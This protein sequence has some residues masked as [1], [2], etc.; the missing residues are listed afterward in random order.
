MT[1]I[2]GNVLT[3]RLLILFLILFFAYSC[4]STNKDAT[5]NAQ[6]DKLPALEF[7]K[8]E[9][10]RQ[11]TEKRLEFRTAYP[12]LINFVNEK[13]AAN[14]NDSI[15][16][17]TDSVYN[18]FLSYIPAVE[19]LEQIPDDFINSYDMD[20]HIYFDKYGIASIRFSEY[21]YIA[22][23]A[24]GMTNFYSENYDLLKFK[25][26]TLDDIFANDEYLDSL[27]SIS[28]EILYERSSEQGMRPDSNWIQ[29]GTKP[30]KLYFRCFNLTEKGLLFTFGPY[31]VASYAEGPQEITIPYSWVE[32]ILDKNS[33]A[34]I[35]AEMNGE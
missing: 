25:K 33:A 27:S 31:Q 15:R 17:F 19:E 2:R 5:L 1:F 10:N 20:Y 11:D 23:A 26:I 12:K 24:H 3:L 28:R 18:N 13:I 21:K 35:I 30:E 34:A 29:E 6:R 16:A 7:D 32:G 22:G 8:A 14:F 9:V 4:R